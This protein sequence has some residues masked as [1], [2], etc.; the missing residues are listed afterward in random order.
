MKGE[1]VLELDQ[2]RALDYL[3]QYLLQDVEVGDVADQ[4]SP[5]W[6]G[7]S[8]QFNMIT[9]SFTSEFRFGNQ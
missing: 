1:I 3:V 6:S 9:A 2:G 8:S 4:P 7:S 5:S